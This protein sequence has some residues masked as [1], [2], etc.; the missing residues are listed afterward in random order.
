MFV[1]AN[2]R[3]QREAVDHNKDNPSLNIAEVAYDVGFNDP[4]YFSKCFSKE[5]GYPPSSIAS[6]DSLVHSEE[7]S[8]TGR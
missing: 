8:M 5:Y 4:K 3:P 7:D 2:R 1:M 6:S